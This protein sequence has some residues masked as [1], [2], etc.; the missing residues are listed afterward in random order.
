MLTIIVAVIQIQC[1]ICLFDPISAAIGG[2][3]GA[4]LLAT[5]GYNKFV[6]CQ[7]GECCNDDYIPIDVEGMHDNSYY[8]VYCIHIILYTIFI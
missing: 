7:I 4:G 6:K 8:I 1:A 5:T 2:A 3:I